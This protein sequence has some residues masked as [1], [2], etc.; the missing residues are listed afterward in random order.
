L[1]DAK[2]I[3]Q[4][5]DPLDTCQSNFRQLVA[6]TSPFHDYSYDLLDTGRYYLL[7][8]R[9]MTHWR[10]QFPRRILEVDYETLVESQEAS[11]WQLPQFCNLTWNDACL[12]FED[13]E[14]PATTAS[15][16]QVRAPMYRTAMQRWKHC[17]KEMDDPQKLLTQAGIALV[18]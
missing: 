14:A 1:P 9:L 6:P 13:N 12:N 16:V 11:T 10:E 7:F 4:R 17:E 2:I 15:A 18:P 8:D 5:R 3:C